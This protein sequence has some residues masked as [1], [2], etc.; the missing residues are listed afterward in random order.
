MGF[1]KK[2]GFIT[3]AGMLLLH[4]LVPHFH[5]EQL[6]YEAHQSLHKAANDHLVD[7]LKFTFHENAGGTEFWSMGENPT[8]VHFDLEGV[9]TLGK[10]SLAPYE[11]KKGKGGIKMYSG[12]GIPKTDFIFTTGGLRAPPA[13]H[14]FY[15][16]SNFI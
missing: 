7:F 10:A 1:F 12:L 9:A 6:S 14:D 16:V 2:I 5:Q 15:Q 13:I 11:I 4:A 8:E 3:T